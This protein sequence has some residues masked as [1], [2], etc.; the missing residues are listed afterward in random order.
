MDA[1]DRPWTTTDW[2]RHLE[3]ALS[4]PVEVR[5]GRARHR[6]LVA[7]PVRI[8][9]LQGWRVRLNARFADAPPAVRDA[10]ANWMRTGRRARRACGVLDAWIDELGRELEAEPRK[11]PP[12]RP[13]GAC[14]DLRAL[15]DE[16]VP[17]QL[18]HAL[19]PPERFPAL[20]WGR[21][22]KSAA[23]RS[24]RLG[25]FEPGLALV[26]MHPVLDQA[27]VP[28]WFVRYVLFHELLHAAIP[29]R[30]G[31]G[32]RTVHHPPEFRKLESAYPD[33]ERA[34]AWQDANLPAL[35]RSARTGAPLRASGARGV[36]QRLLF[37]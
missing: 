4:A 24:L 37:R 36:L 11:L 30:A 7:E 5:Y 29:P 16:L 18:P 23:R 2:A 12:L 6:V 3:D 8:G 10:V 14:Y 20:T 26:R 28:I 32:G 21:R 33:F 27:G 31:S 1:P 25:S 19:L 13:S 17:R 9:T 34:T 35:M 22:Q 15:A